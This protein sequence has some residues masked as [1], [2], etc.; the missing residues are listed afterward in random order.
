MIQ[1]IDRDENIAGIG[2]TSS[3]SLPETPSDY[4]DQIGLSNPIP[5]VTSML[6]KDLYMKMHT[7]VT[8]Q[9]DIPKSLIVF[10]GDV[11]TDNLMWSHQDGETK[12]MTDAALTGEGFCN[13]GEL[14]EV[15]TKAHNFYPEGLSAKWDA[16]HKVDNLCKEK[17]FTFLELCNKT[18]DFHIV[19]DFMKYRNPDVEEFVREFYSNIQWLF[20]YNLLFKIY[21]VGISPDEENFITLYLALFHAYAVR[22]IVYQINLIT[23]S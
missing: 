10:I 13:G 1:N 15:L 9:S 17:N 8:N 22:I 2:I 12:F 11:A 14:T 7:M 21:G 19:P 20:I 6:D 18:K 23:M 3:V 16:I 4:V 5:I